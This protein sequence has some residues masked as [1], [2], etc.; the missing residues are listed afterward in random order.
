MTTIDTLCAGKKPTVGWTAGTG[1]I[2][3]DTLYKTA[4][5]NA[6][7]CLPNAGAGFSQSTDYNSDGTVKTASLDTQISIILTAKSANVP[8]Q[9]SITAD[10]GGD[11]QAQL[12]ATNAKVVR[13]ALL[14]EYCYYSACYLFALERLLDAASNVNTA[15]TITY[16]STGTISPTTVIYTASGVSKTY[17]S[18]TVSG[19]TVT[20]T[21]L[22][23]DV[24]NLN[25][26][27][28]QLIQLI[29]RLQIKRYDDL[30]TKFYTAFSSTDS[31]SLNTMLSTTKTNLMAQSDKLKN[32]D[33][34]MN[35]KQSMID[36]TLE[37]NASS[38]NL[39]AVYGFMNIVAVGLLFYMYKASK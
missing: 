38:R 2:A 17:G 20:A 27:L 19:T 8:E 11:A 18:I 6:Y 39:L 28:N 5:P 34:E 1:V 23:G 33:F 22:M 15:T 10:V 36:Y 35:V 13:D 29:Q 31:T 12:F 26:K 30:N 21:G 32:G 3:Y 37:K 9:S 7:E 25:S 24:Y 16:T 14:A 4:Y